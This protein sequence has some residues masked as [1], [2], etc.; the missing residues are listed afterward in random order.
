MCW[1]FKEK[2]GRLPRAVLTEQGAKCNLQAKEKR[3]AEEEQEG[4]AA[5]AIKEARVLREAQ[6]Q[7]KYQWIHVY[8]PRFLGNHCSKLDVLYV[9]SLI[10][11][12]EK[13][14]RIAMSVRII[15][16]PQDNTK[17]WAG[18]NKTM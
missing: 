14:V 17:F 4:G 15:E 3:G 16:Y 6:S 9:A 7:R 12:G 1:D 10:H 2:S 8:G 13:E 5:T 11:T 18:L